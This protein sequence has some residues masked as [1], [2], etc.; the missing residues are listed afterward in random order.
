MINISIPLLQSMSMTKTCKEAKDC[1]VQASAQDTLLPE[2]G[3]VQLGSPKATW[4]A[5]ALRLSG[6]L[7]ANC[8]STT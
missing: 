8:K 2:Q 7:A 5:R 6:I 3:N 4:G 1:M